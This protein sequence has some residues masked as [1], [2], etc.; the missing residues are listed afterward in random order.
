MHLSN[1]VMPLDRYCE[2]LWNKKERPVNAWSS[3]L[4]HEATHHHGREQHQEC[5]GLFTALSFMTRSNASGEKLLA[6]QQR[7][8]G[9]THNLSGEKHELPET[10]PELT[11]L[12]FLFLLSLF[13]VWQTS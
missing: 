1:K 5:K 11:S 10:E 4:S 12:I 2:G 8:T 13:C 6:T 7:N 9:G 3:P